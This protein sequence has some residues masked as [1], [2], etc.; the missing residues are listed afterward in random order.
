MIPTTSLRKC[1][2][3]VG[4]LKPGIVCDVMT[5]MY[6][7]I[8]STRIV[9]YE[10]IFEIIVLCALSRGTHTLASMVC[11]CRRVKLV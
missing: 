2:V 7:F 6:F 8:L 1:S 3:V 4:S 10:L 5:V 9:S 11:N